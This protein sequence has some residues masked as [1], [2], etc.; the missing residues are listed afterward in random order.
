MS[1]TGM[2]CDRATLH[3]YGLSQPGEGAVL[4]LYILYIVLPSDMCG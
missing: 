3:N 4:V 1:I 2:I